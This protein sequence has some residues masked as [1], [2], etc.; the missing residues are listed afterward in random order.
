[1]QQV[2]LAAIS[3]AL[4][5][6]ALGGEARAWGNEGHQVVALIAR[7]HLA[8]PVRRRVEQLMAG[9]RDTL[10]G[11]D[12]ASRATWADAWRRGHPETGPW[13]YVNLELDHPD[14]R[15]ACRSRRSCVVDKI[16]D[17]A[18]ELANPAAP[19]ARK[20]FALK[21]VLHLVGDLHQPLHAADAHDHGGNCERVTFTPKGSFGLRLW[22][23]GETSLH[24]YWDDAGVEA[25]GESPQG[26]AAALERQ[27]T[28]HDVELWSRGGPADWAMETF[29]V[30]RD[31]AY[32]YGGPLACGSAAATPLTRAYQDQARRVTGQQLSRAGIRLAVVL[33]RALSR[34]G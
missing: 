17:F 23:V 3:A 29:A 26:V 13:H 16:D 24:R 11:P 20:I 33:N 7:D 1:M 4:A 19:E 8:P 28:R 10:T 18:S 14:L 32:H 5:F 22:P 6:A 25:L 27:I 12:I 31:A 34:G 30:G 21:M 15:Q 9:D 2:R